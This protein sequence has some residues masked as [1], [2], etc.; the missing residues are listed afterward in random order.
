MI[1]HVA[2]AIGFVQG[3]AGAPKR[4]FPGQKVLRMRVPAHGDDVRV[5][6][7]Q[8]PVADEPFLSF[9]NQARLQRVRIRPPHQPEV[10]NRQLM[11]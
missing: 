8:Q 10:L 1:C 2:A 5:F 4:I 6:H 7:K 3:N 9:G 11:H